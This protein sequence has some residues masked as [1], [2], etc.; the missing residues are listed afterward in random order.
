MKK[1]VNPTKLTT[2]WAEKKEKTDLPGYPLY[3]SGEDIFSKS[4]EEENINSEDVA[5]KNN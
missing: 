5:S 4:K 3:P 1:Q 2:E